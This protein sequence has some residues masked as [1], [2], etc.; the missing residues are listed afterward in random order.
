MPEDPPS[1]LFVNQ[2]YA[3]DLASTAQHLTDLA[4]HLAAD[5]FEVHVLCSRGHYLSGE[6]DVPAEETRNGVHVHRVRTTAF[7]RETTLGRIADYAS[8]FLQ[9]LR[10][11]LKGPRY[12]AVV[13]LTTPP[14]LPVAM[15]AA[16]LLRGQP[17][18]IWSMDLHPEAEQAVGMI[19]EDGRLARVLQGLADWSYRRAAFTVDLGPHMKERIR[20]KGVPDERLH[21]IPVWNKRDEVYPIPDD[22]NP[23][24][25]KVGLED[26]F[27]VMY[28]GNAG[29][30]H[31]FDE[32]LRAA[33][34]FDGRK[35][36]IHFLFVGSGPRREEIE[37]F[38][39]TRGLSNLT[40]LDYFPR[41]QIKFS[42][43]LADVHLLTLRR[44]FAG[45]AVPGKL[46]GILASGTPAL[47]VGPEASDP[48]KTIQH[49][50]VG[51]VVDPSS[52]D[53]E[54]AATEAVIGAI[55][56]LRD[57]P[58]EQQ[59]VGARGREVFLSRFEQETCCEKWTAILRQELETP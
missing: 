14:L 17:Y 20:A 7:G 25:E 46:Y 39:E 12:D 59:S 56:H 30:G 34:H 57:H 23:L 18:G 49:H 52:F 1:L 54:A 2:H 48:A 53:A 15:A 45:I 58:D 3:P 16:R 26:K 24:M 28:S 37:R 11:L 6:M 21:T 31:R 55:Q 44:S 4:E 42:L 50:E 33:E 41:D 29:L 10:R 9:V 40:Y 19:A 43:S 27:V 47:M 51:T 13:S 38:A 22:Q 8:F 32:V 36:G 35:E 5:G